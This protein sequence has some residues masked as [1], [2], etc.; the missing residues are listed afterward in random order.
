MTIPA[1]APNP[2]G[3]H[4]F[5]NFILESDVGAQLSNYIAYATP[6]EASLPEIDEE[7]RKDERIYPP[8]A[9]IAK[10]VMLEDVAEA[11]TLY[12]QVWTRLKAGQ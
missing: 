11:T 5:I 7:T 12:D 8:E 4:R 6:N 1:K 9:Q 3:A 2:D 10:M